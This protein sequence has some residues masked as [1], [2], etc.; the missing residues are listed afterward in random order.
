[1]APQVLPRLAGLTVG[2]TGRAV[3]G[4]G[5]EG[6]AGLAGGDAG[7]VVRGHIILEWEVDA[8]EAV[9]FGGAQFA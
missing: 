5:D 4:R 1:M 7:G 3:G 8:L 9:Q 6:A 2:G